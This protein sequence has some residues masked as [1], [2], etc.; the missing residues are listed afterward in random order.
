MAELLEILMVVSFGASWPLNEIKS[1]S[2]RTT[3]GKR[4]AFL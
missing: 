3:K 1:Y 4:L 2:E